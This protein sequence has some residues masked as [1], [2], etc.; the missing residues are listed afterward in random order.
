MP[1]AITAATAALA[2]IAGP[3][4]VLITTTLVER[5][6]RNVGD[7]AINAVVGAVRGRTLL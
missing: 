4:Q 1:L 5:L 7:Y 6:V 3:L 2:R